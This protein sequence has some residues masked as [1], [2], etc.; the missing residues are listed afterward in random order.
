MMRVV[1]L[2]ALFLLNVNIVFAE[3]PTNTTT[4]TVIK[5]TYKLK[6]SVVADDQQPQSLN[7]NYSY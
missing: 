5:E 4:Q 7:S 3:E 1:F 6:G 2:I